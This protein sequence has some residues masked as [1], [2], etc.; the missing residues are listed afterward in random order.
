M[1][2]I[3]LRRDTAANWTANGTVVLAAGE[4]GLESDTKKIKYG[5][6][7]TTWNNLS[8]LDY[9]AGATGATGATG[10]AGASGS[11]NIIMIATPAGTLNFPSAANTSTTNN[12]TLITSGGV[13]GVSVSTTSFTLPAGTYLMRWPE[14]N[15]STYGGSIS[16]RLFNTTDNSETQLLDSFARRIDASTGQVYI[17]PS[18]AYFTIAATKTFQIRTNT[19][20][21]YLGAGTVLAPNGRFII[22]FIKTA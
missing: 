3:R 9:T 2:A 11:N 21:P 13:S 22:T 17:Y 1:T 20:A 18:N 8:Y 14:G 5:D 12:W 10:P 4:P 15:Y 6:G 19:N 16:L 7:T